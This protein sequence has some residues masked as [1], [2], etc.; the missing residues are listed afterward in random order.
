MG[1]IIVGVLRGG[2]SGEYKISLK[3]GGNVLANLPAKYK[4][5]DILITKDGVWHMDGI[6]ALPEKIF[7]TVDVIFNCLHGTYGEDG[8]VQQLL[9]SFDVAYTGSGVFASVVGMNKISSKGVFATTGL[10]MPQFITT[11][12]NAS[13]PVFTKQVFNKISPPWIVKPARGGSSLGVGVVKSL[14]ELEGALRNAFVY[15]PRAVVEEYLQG[16]EA[17]CGIIDNFRN[18]QFYSLPVVE[19][20]PP[21]ESQ[22]FDYEAKYSGNTRELCPSN[23][24]AEV[25]RK[26]EEVARKAHEALGCRHYSRSDFIVTKKGEVYILETNTLP[27]LTKES[28]FPKSLEAVGIGYSEFLDHLVN[29]ARQSQ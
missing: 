14:P 29:L 27:G 21:P 17:T 6:I 28:L 20:I 22:F 5:R 12:K 16:V 23:F 25:R 18:K 3:T 11:T 19:I 10:K 2:P 8:L 7:R 15:D 13:L 1:K 24:S 4:K 9:D 26:I